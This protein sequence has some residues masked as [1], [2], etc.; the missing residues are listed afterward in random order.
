ME[1]EHGPLEKEKHLQIASFWVPCLFSR[2]YV[3]WS[4][5][6]G[7]FFF[8]TLC[9]LGCFSMGFFIQGQWTRFTGKWPSVKLKSQFYLTHLTPTFIDV[10]GSN[11]SVIYLHEKV[12]K[13]PHEPWG[14]GL[15]NIPYLHGSYGNG[16]R[17]HQIGWYPGNSRVFPFQKSYML[18]AQTSC[19]RSL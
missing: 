13:W 12:T 17:F 4:S 14:N 18:S 11:V 9:I 2:G 5:M 16:I 8:R 3:G 10:I 1:P 19:F 7:V 6:Q 15:V